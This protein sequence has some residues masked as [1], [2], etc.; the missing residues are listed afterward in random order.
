MYHNL[1]TSSVK[2]KNYLLHQKANCFEVIPVHS[3]SHFAFKKAQSKNFKQ[4]QAEGDFFP[5]FSFLCWFI[6][7]TLS[8]AL[9]VYTTQH[10]TGS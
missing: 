6:K 7:S 9:Y 8:D 1:L 5:P 2:K 4:V 3:K 10:C